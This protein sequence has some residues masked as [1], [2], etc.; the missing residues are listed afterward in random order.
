MG[1]ST[2]ADIPRRI[3]RLLVLWQKCG[4]D[5]SVVSDHNVRR[6]NF[7]GKHIA[8][9][10]PPGIELATLDKLYG[11]F[12]S[13][14]REREPDCEIA[15]EIGEPDLNSFGAVRPAYYTPRNVV[16]FH[17]GQKIVNYHGRALVLQNREGSRARV[18]ARNEDILQSVAYNLLQFQMSIHADAIGRYRVHALA[19]SFNGKGVLVLL[20][21]GGGKSTLTLELLK[22]GEIKLISEDAPLIDGSGRIYPHPV[23]IGRLKGEIPEGV[24]AEFVGEI[25][26][27]DGNTKEFLDIRC[28]RSRIEESP[29]KIAAIYS[30]QRFLGDRVEIVPQSYCSML[31]EFFSVCVSGVGLYQGLEFALTRS[32]RELLGY[33][34]LGLRRFY[35]AARF[36]A[37][38]ERY[39]FR[40][41]TNVKRNTEELLKHLDATL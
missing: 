22:R 17:E 4:V 18:I 24:P 7:Y 13:D 26:Y 41:G 27:M 2:S 40:M 20:P 8:I 19:F 37:G 12:N 32:V 5:S 36:I 14:R 29:V 11:F 30:G 33:A 25:Q 9:R 31:R 10:C 39:E 28:F 23:S 15:L 21:R 16:Y 1:R 34:W 6:L 38:G 3:D 35:A